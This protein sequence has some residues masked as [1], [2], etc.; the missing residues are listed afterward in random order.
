MDRIGVVGPLPSVERIIEMSRNFEKD[1]QFL[2]YPYQRFQDTR[3]IVREHDHEVDVWLFSGKL[4]YLIA[5]KELGTDENLVHIQHTEASL[6]KCFMMMA[7]EQGRFLERVSID[8]LEETQLNFALQQLEMPHKDVYLKIYNTETHPDE[9]LAF[10]LQ[11]W[12]EGKVD[13]AV[14]CFEGV[15]RGLKEAGVPVYWFTPTRLEIWQTFHI[16]AEKVRTFYFKDTQIGV[17]IVEIEQF[18]RIAEKAKSPYH[19]QHL[20]LRLKE[21]LLHLCEKLNGSLL[22]KG[23]G[24]Y[25]I[26]S[27][28]GAIE[29]ELGVLQNTVQQL[30]LE[31]DSL[32]AVGVGYGETVFSAEINARRAIQQSKSDAK[33]GIVVVQEDGT[34]VEAA[35]QEQ[36]LVYSYR[37]QDKDFVDKLKKGN[38]SARTYNKIEALVRRM[39]WSGFTTKDLATHLQLDERNVR[40]IVAYLCEVELAEC[41]GEE[42][43]STRGRPSKI[44]RLKQES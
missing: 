31:A 7:K 3:E 34:V 4:S 27:S 33:R 37:M 28:R 29:R 18:D 21:V 40:R 39:G 13:G 35:G 6:Y 5:R 20:E 16:V 32:V 42:S 25:V 30:S 9:L 23:D 2:S 10:H 26:F 44:Y 22:E 15:Y 41:V 8:E 14:T 1:L 24:R 12:R 17:E 36:A 19:L 43:A 38:I 11:K